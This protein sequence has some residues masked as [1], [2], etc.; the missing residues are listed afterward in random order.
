MNCIIVSTL[1]ILN[2]A[3]VRHI[4][5]AKIKSVTLHQVMGTNMHHSARFH[6]NRSN[7][8]IVILQFSKLRPSAILDFLNFKFLTVVAVKKPILHHSAEFR[9]NRSDLCGNISIFVIFKRTAAAILVFQ[10][11]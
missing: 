7:R 6:P 9:K 8:N 1:S 11:I 5:L 4:T 2:I 3:A 10:N